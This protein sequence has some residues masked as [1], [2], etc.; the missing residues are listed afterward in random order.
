MV[1]WINNKSISLLSH[2]AVVDCWFEMLLWT[3]R[4]PSNRGYLGFHDCIGHLVCIYIF[5]YNWIGRV[6]LTVINY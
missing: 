4:F 5:R 1:L 2:G 3:K 6:T